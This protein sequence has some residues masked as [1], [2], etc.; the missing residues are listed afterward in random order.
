MVDANPKVLEDEAK[1]ID[2]TDSAPGVYRI[3]MVHQA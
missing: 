2:M 1:F 3:T